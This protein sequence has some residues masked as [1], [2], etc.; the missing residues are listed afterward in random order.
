M[1]KK[2]KLLKM[3]N[4]TFFH[5]VFY[6]TCILTLYSINTHFKLFK[7]TTF[8]NIV[9]KEEIARHEQV[10]LFP[11]CFLLDQNSISPFGNIY[12]IISLFAA[13]LEEPKIDMWG[14]G[15]KSFN[16]NIQI[17]VCSFF[18]FGT[19]SKWCVR[20]R[21]KTSWRQIEV[22]GID[23]LVSIFFKSHFY[24][25]NMSLSFVSIMLFWVLTQKKKITWKNSNIMI[26]ILLHDSLLHTNPIQHFLRLFPYRI[27]CKFLILIKT[28]L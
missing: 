3:S 25:I 6:A 20:K 10:L 11:Q 28:E 23:F 16:S 13:E 1:W 24:Q 14:K 18:E 5:N 4:F 21:V 17:V 26:G 2:G 7:Q 8:E 19:V 27:L 12:D 15:L 22:L 9:G